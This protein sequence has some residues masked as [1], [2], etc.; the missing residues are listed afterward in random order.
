MAFR[1]MFSLPGTRSGCLE[2]PCRGTSGGA[3]QGERGRRRMERRE[4]T[5]RGH[6]SPGEELAGLN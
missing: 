5:Q 6:G 3:P 1:H 4:G 2:H